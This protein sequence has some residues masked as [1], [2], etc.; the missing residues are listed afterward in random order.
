MSM[1][2][3]SKYR[4]AL[5]HLSEDFAGL[6]EYG[7]SL[8]HDLFLAPECDGELADVWNDDDLILLRQSLAQQTSWQQF[9]LSKDRSYVHRYWSTEDAGSAIP[10]FELAAEIGWNLLLAMSRLKPCDTP[11]DFCADLVQPQKNISAAS[12]WLCLLHEMAF[13]YPSSGLKGT[14][15]FHSFDEQI[16]VSNSILSDVISGSAA[17][18]DLIVN[19]NHVSEF[20]SWECRLELELPEPIP[21]PFW[22][23]EAGE[24]WFDGCL[25]KQFK[26]PA[27][28]Q[29]TVLDAFHN[30]EWLA[31]IDQPF[32]NHDFDYSNHPAK[33]A[34]D[35]I[36]R[37]LR[38]FPIRFGTTDNGRKM[39]W[40]IV[41]SD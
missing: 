8:N 19:T 14:C 17:L 2:R 32:G 3:Y 5:I 12:A 16:C 7:S 9:C 22:N 31:V 36:N 37:S 30:E 23:S 41:D 4:N 28:N 34:A 10:R 40:K 6:A 26:K 21:T 33:R 11:A 1:V 38:Q 24:L 29:R 18:I 13:R 25:L 39:T 15:C 20:G 27:F 35:D